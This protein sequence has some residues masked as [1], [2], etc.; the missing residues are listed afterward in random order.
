[1]GKI[2]EVF[3]KLGYAAYVIVFR[4]FK[5]KFFAYLKEYRSES[6]II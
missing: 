3:R 5:G 2:K 4:S 6:E 1:M